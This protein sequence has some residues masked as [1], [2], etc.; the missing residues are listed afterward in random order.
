MYIDKIYNLFD[1]YQIFK[2]PVLLFIA[3]PKNEKI[4]D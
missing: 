1:V 4:V 2:C 3:K